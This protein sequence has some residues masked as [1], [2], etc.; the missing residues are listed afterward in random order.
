MTSNASI[1]RKAY[2]DFATGDVPSVL[3]VFDPSI[4]WQV[5]GHSPLSGTYKG[6]DEVLGFFKRTMELRSL[7]RGPASGG[8]E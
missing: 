4:T 1:V 2:Q 8:P 5:P 6:H 3:A 7:S